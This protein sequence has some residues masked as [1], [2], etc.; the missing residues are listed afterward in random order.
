MARISIFS[1][2][3][4]CGLLDLG[5][6]LSGY[7]VVMV[8]EKYSPF[9]NAYQYSRKVMKFRKPKYGYKNIDIN[10][11]LYNDQY[12]YDAISKERDAN[13]FIGFIGGP[14][15]PDFSVAGKNKGE[16]GDNGILTKSYFDL[17]IK[18]KP[19]FFVFE[20]VKGLWKTKKHRS[21][22]DKMV[23]T[24]KKNCYFITDRL[25][26]SLEYG[27][28]QDRE[29]IVMIGIR[30][31]N[32]AEI[33]IIA[34]K[35]KSFS[36]GISNNMLD[37]IKN[38]DWPDTEEFVENSISICP[39]HV[40]KK[41]TV[42][43]WFDKNDVDNHFNAKDFFTPRKGLEKMKTIKEGDVSRKS[44]KRLHRWRYSPTAAY[45]NNEVHL[46]PYKCRRLSVA[47]VLAIQSAPPN[48]CLPETMTLTDK[49]KTVGNGV[50]V[51][52]AQKLSADLY[53]LL[54][55][56]IRSKENAIQS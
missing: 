46:H 28:P 36:W 40:I 25:L 19:D 47:E 16:K 50:P 21:F 20:N 39:S 1:F 23:K 27:V 34:D 32:Q 3:S 7:D 43:Y 48:F 22:Y 49:F 24:L 41:Y 30:Y 51:I 33:N 10:D 45:G 35:I 2:F 56:I 55:E 26:N 13:Q 14:P 5:F 8:N 44:Y 12:L 6:E 11:Y 42:Q 4:G 54:N 52:M 15:C 53:A 37:V 17:I 9:I 18:E 38:I 31:N 29:R